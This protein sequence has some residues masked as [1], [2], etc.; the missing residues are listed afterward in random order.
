[1]PTEYTAENLVMGPAKIYIAPFGTTEPADASVNSAPLASAGWVYLGGTNDGVEKTLEQTYENFQVD[2]SVM[3][4]GARLTEVSF[5]VKT[6]L[7][8]PTLQNLVYVL[9]DGSTASGVGYETYE[10]EFGSSATQSTYRALI[11]DGYAPGGND[12]KRRVIIRKVLSTDNVEFAYKSDT[13]T[14]FSVQWEAFD[15]GNGA[16][17]KFIDEVA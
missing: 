4:P 1:M 6:N 12:L 17:Y 5:K 16:P 2:Q 15:P 13:Q 8:E 3:S 10:P 11:I 9:N 7:A 14:V